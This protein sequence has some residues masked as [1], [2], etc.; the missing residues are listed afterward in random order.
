MATPLLMRSLLWGPLLVF[1]VP[2]VCLAQALPLGQSGVILRENSFQFRERAVV[3]G[4]A[5][6]LARLTLRLPTASLVSLQAHTSATS[7]RGAVTFALALSSGGP[8]PDIRRLGWPQSGRFVT[9]PAQGQWV[10]CGT[11]AVVQLPAGSHTIDFAVGDVRG[12]S[13]VFDAGN[14]TALAVPVGPASGTGGAIRKEAL[15]VGINDYQSSSVPDLR[16]CVNDVRAMRGLLLGSLGFNEQ[17]VRILEDQQATRRQILAELEGLVQRADPNTLVIFFFSGHGSQYRRGSGDERYDETLVA[18][19]SRV[20]N[21]DDILDDE[22]G[23]ILRQLSRRAGHV[24]FVVDSCHSGGANR[25]LGATAKTIPVRIR[26]RARSA[27]EDIDGLADRG[28]DDYVFITACREEE[29]AY[30]VYNNRIGHNGALTYYFL[31]ELRRSANLPIT[32]QELMDR[33]RPAVR[34]RRDQM[35]QLLGAKAQELVFHLQPLAQRPIV[36]AQPE[37]DAVRL[38][39][40]IL[41]GMT[42][43]SRYD[44]FRPN[45]QRL[46]QPK[47]RIA[48]AEITEL[49]PN[50][51]LA[52]IAQLLEGEKVL[53][54]SQAVE[55]YHVPGDDSF[56]VFVDT[57]GST[58]Q[59]AVAGSTLLA[60]VVA[61]WEEDLRFARRFPRTGRPSEA[62]FYLSELREANLALSD[63]DRD[64]AIIRIDPQESWQQ[65]L[66]KV[67][68]AF[69]YWA[70]WA[71]LVDLENPGDGLDVELSLQADSSREATRQRGAAVA[72]GLTL[73]EGQRVSLKVTNRSQQTVFVALLGL[74]ADGSVEVLLGSRDNPAAKLKPGETWENE[75]KVRMLSAEGVT[76]GV[77][78]TGVRVWTPIA[79]EPG[80]APGE[81]ASRGS[82]FSSGSQEMLKLVASTQEL[83]FSFVTQKPEMILN[84]A[85]LQAPRAAQQ[86]FATTILQGRVLPKRRGRAAQV[87]VR[88]WTTRTAVYDVVAQ[89]QQ[90]TRGEIRLPEHDN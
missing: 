28:R 33:V 62:H 67:R 16:G 25:A 23:L 75:A 79:P 1:L 64:L 59:D 34:A 90:S 57:N 81:R 18:Y 10:P 36:L 7:P 54:D 13:V 63:G 17:D 53:P 4:E 77:R 22:I 51:A 74:H 86:T 83:D 24:V 9:V 60:R 30:E 37:G 39:G 61:S 32:Y 14:L 26:P 40:G 43:G 69:F 11:S 55:T 84:Q 73:Q 49:T 70:N 72:A 76:R 66:R 46:S 68:A 3:G 38:A 31:R 56:R 8:P 27:A 88:Q 35:P 15:L 5:R 71:A 19:D 50:F 21:R 65:R 85:E 89:S 44:I 45:E 29:L 87:P 12:G 78:E 6:T 82:G 52:Q 47:H 42:V 48:E 2:S 80:R 20:G 58:R 41:R